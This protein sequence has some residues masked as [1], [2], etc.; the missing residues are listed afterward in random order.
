MNIQETLYNP[1]I[2]IWDFLKQFVP[3]TACYKDIKYFSRRYEDK[4]VIW[5]IYYNSGKI[6]EIRIDY[7]QVEQN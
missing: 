7:S 2:Q 1:S 5:R 6:D 3:A 4:I